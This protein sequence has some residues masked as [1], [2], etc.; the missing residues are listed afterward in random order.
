MRGALRVIRGRSVRARACALALL[1]ELLVAAPGCLAEHAARVVRTLT[2]ALADR[3]TAS[4]MKIETLVFVVWLVR[5]HGRGMRAHAAALL[6]AVLACVHDPFYKVTAEALRVLQT[7]V[8]VMR[9]LG[10][11]E[12]MLH[13]ITTNV[14]TTKRLFYFIDSA[15]LQTH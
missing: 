5:G 6:P 1:R 12:L 8:K 10:T 14:N 13:Y 11:P 2:P 15:H 3:G 4:S 7:L 9:P